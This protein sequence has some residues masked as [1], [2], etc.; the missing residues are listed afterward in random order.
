MKA[1]S[2]VIRL[3]IAKNPSST[4]LLDKYGIC[5]KKETRREI[6]RIKNEIRDQR[7]EQRV[8]VVGTNPRKSDKIWAHTRDWLQYASIIVS[9]QSEMVF[10]FFVSVTFA[11]S[12][13]EWWTYDGISGIFIAFIFFLYFLD[14]CLLLIVCE[15]NQNFHTDSVHF[16]S[17]WKNILYF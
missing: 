11:V 8:A 4:K 1:D 16:R 6:I 13:E 7:I 10:F 14:L 9:N 17:F 3:L 2:L 12:W 15:I 5:L